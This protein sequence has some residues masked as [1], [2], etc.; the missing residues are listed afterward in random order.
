MLTLMRKDLLLHKMTFYCA[1]PALV[2][3]VGWFASQRDLRGAF[4]TFDCIIAGVLP[5]VLIAREDIFRV[6]AFICS[7]PVTRR[8]VVRA[9]YVISWA[10]ALTFTVVGLI[11]YSIFATERLHEIWSVSTASRVLVMLSVGLGVA[12]PLALRFGWIGL[13]VFGVGIQILAM[14]LYIIAKTFV[15]RL[16]LPDVFKAVSESIEGL[17]SWLGDPL[18]L[19]AVIV[20]L[21]TFNFASYKIAEALFERREF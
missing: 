18:F 13:T 17:H 11:L 2:A 6:E 5:M 8:Q 21:A 20:I 7:L 19:A 12:L 10:I 16:R 9:K 15:T 14:G 1:T 4:I 3:Y